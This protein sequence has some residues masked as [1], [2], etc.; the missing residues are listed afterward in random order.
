MEI[1]VQLNDVN[2]RLIERVCDDVEEQTGVDVDNWIDV[3]DILAILDSLEDKYSDTLDEF[4]EYKEHILQN[5]KPVGEE[6]NWRF[7][8]NTISKLEEECSNMWNFIKER[9][10]EE[11]YGKNNR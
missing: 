11:E 8:S 4:K 9:G 10:L 3:D 6:D 5:Y 2:R 1:K 7:Y